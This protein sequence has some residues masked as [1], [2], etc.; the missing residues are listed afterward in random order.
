MEINDG[1]SAL[2]SR[3][4]SMGVDN[5][6]VSAMGDMS[7]AAQPPGGPG[8]DTPQE[9]KAVQ[10]LTKGAQLIRE[11]ANAEPSIRII[12]DKTLQDLFMQIT[13]HYGMEEEGKL[14][15]RQAKLGADRQRAVALTGPPGGPPSP[16]PAGP[17]GPVTGPPM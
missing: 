7:T 11:A 1:L 12:V 5:P 16:P 8:I 9:Q 14:A 17:G 6:D 13:K 3:D 10:L 2:A 15:L 4:T